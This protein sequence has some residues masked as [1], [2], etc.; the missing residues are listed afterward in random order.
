MERGDGILINEADYGPPM[1]EIVRL[2]GDEATVDTLTRLE[3][4][5]LYVFA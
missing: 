2:R 1:A 4:D 5:V 3:R